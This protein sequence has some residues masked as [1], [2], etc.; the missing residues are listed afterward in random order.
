[1][2]RLRNKPINRIL[3][4]TGLL[5]LFSF[6][7]LFATYHS[8]IN[9]NIAYAQTPSQGCS[10]EGCATPVKEDKDRTPE[11]IEAREAYKD[12]LLFT[13]AICGTAA[14]VK[15]MVVACAVMAAKA[16]QLKWKVIKEC[17]FWDSGV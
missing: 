10:S 12:H 8:G 11:C 7:S 15:P 9:S 14:V 6:T 2:F 13:A 5:L 16:G 17:G 4:A 1:M 3:T